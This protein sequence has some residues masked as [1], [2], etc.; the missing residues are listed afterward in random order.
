MQ[1]TCN[2]YLFLHAKFSNFTCK[3]YILHVKSIFL[4]ANYMRTACE[5]VLFLH[6]ILQIYACENYDFVCKLHAKYMRIITEFCMRYCC[7]IMTILHAN[8]M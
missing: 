6:V 4:H 8:R 5:F 2:I 7:E 3:N 1:I